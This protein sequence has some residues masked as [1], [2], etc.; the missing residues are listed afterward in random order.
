MFKHTAVGGKVFIY[1]Y[2]SCWMKKKKNLEFPLISMLKADVSTHR[3]V[4]NWQCT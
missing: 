4:Y 3:H 2:L 1:T